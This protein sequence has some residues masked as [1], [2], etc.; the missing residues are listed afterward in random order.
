MRFFLW[1]S[2]LIIVFTYNISRADKKSFRPHLE[3]SRHTVSTSMALSEQNQQN[4]YAPSEDSDQPGH[5][6]NLIRVCCAL[7]G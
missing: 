6:S 5:P 1:V 7:G 4:E 3:Q 2:I